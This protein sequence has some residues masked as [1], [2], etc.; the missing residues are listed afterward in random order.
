[1]LWL[2]TNVVIGVINRRSPNLATK[3]DTELDR[4]TAIRLSAVV[5]FELR[6]GIAR[7]SRRSENT[8]VL[9]QF[10][11]TPIEVVAFDHE[12]AAEAASIRMLLE[13]SGTPISHYDIL[14]AAQARRRGEVLVTANTREFA[15]IPGLSMIDWSI[16]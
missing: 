10:L 15:R 6:Y 14:I 12:D 13:Q 2:D 9:D 5:V 7:S 11:S 3:F 4:G 1:V 16:T 8:A